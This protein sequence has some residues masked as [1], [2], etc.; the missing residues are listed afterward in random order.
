[1][2]SYA[3]ST[4]NAV[5]FQCCGQ[6]P[7]NYVVWPLYAITIQKIPRQKNA[8][9]KRWLDNSNHSTWHLNST[10]C[11]LFMS[12]N[13]QCIL[14]RKLNAL[15]I[16]LY[17]ITVDTYFYNALI[18]IPFLCLIRCENAFHIFSSFYHS[19]SKEYKLRLCHLIYYIDHTFFIFFIL[20]WC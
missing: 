18:Q 13:F 9:E 19:R 20:E 15:I 8:P 6:I 12:I 10:C 4:Q 14:E 17:W 7:Q 16:F 11:N 5:I 1:M 2:T 3:F